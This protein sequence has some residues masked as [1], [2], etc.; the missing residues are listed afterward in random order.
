MTGWVIISTIKDIPSPV[1]LSKFPSKDALPTPFNRGL[2]SV[3]TDVIIAGRLWKIFLSCLFLIM[4]MHVSVWG[5]VHGSAGARRRSSVSDPR[6]LELQ[7]G[8]EPPNIG[9]GI[10]GPL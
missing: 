7:G 2:I 3:T 4:C 8:C 5:S 6:K 1:M 9:A 10:I